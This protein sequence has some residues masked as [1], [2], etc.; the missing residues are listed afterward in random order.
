[1]QKSDSREK[2]CAHKLLTIFMDPFTPPTKYGGPTTIK[3]TG[4][5]PAHT[6]AHENLTI[7]Y[8]SFYFYRKMWAK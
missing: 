1:M 4:E 2:S 6:F 8:E 5:N 3:K 7:F